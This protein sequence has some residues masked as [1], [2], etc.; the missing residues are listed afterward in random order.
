MRF[1][2]EPPSYPAPRLPLSDW[3]KVYGLCARYAR[4]SICRTSSSANSA[5]SVASMR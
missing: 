5:L 1:R 2:A 4:M 3:I